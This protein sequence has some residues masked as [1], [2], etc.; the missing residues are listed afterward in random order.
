[1]VF[2][3][4]SYAVLSEHGKA[5]TSARSNQSSLLA[6]VLIENWGTHLLPSLVKGGFANGRD[7]I[8]RGFGVGESGKVQ[9]C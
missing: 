2:F 4:F 1:M 3:F 6:F 9:R 8:R 5:K 7:V